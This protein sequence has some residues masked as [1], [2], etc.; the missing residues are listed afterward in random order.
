MPI[1]VAK[2]Y[3]GKVQDVVLARSYDLANAYWHGKGVIAHSIVTLREG[4]LNDHPT[5]V[6]PVVATTE[7]TMRQEF[8]TGSLS[9]LI[10][11]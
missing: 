5:G 10:I 11:D 4:D 6:L 8:G 3:D 1:F 2:R 9:V 7:K